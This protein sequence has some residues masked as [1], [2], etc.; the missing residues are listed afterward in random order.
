MGELTILDLRER[1][2]EA[3]GERFDL[4]D[5]HDVVISHGSLPMALLEREVERDIDATAASLP[6]SAR[7]DR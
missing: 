2:R 7:A 5:F 6:V 4:T 1:A 3:L